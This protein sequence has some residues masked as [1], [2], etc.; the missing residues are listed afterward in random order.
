MEIGPSGNSNRDF[1]NVPPGSAR[2][3]TGCEFCG[4]A[5]SAASPTSR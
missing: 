2:P 3:A 1:G 4:P 5:V